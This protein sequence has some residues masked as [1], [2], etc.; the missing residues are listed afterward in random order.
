MI[1][2][3]TFDRLQNKSGNIIE[4]LNSHLEKIDAKYENFLVILGNY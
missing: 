2:F 1:I 4:H 3:N